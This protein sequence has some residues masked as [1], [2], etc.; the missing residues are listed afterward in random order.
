LRDVIYRMYDKTLIVI[1]VLIIGFVLLNLNTSVV[2]GLKNPFNSKSIKKSFDK[3]VKKASDSVKKNADAAKKKTDDFFKKDSKKSSNDDDEESNSLSVA[4][5]ATATAATATAA[6][7]TAATATAATVEPIQTINDVAQAPLPVDFR[8]VNGYLE[9]I[10][11][12][13]SDA[14]TMST[15]IR[16]SVEEYKRAYDEASNNLTRL[17]DATKSNADSTKTIAEEALRQMDAIQ[18][19]ISTKAVDIQAQVNSNNI[20]K[21]EIG[22]RMNEMRD[23]E[24]NVSDKFIDVK[25]SEMNAAQSAEDARRALA[26]ILPT[27][28]N[29]NVTQSVGAQSVEGFT[30]FKTS[31]LE[32]YTVYSNPNSTSSGATNKNAFDLENDLVDKINNFNTAYYTYLSQQTPTAIQSTA[33]TTARTNL[34]TAISNLNTHISSINSSTP[35][36]SDAVF[37]ASHSYIKTTASQIDTLRSDLDMKMLEILKA[38][39][40]TP[41][42]HTINHDAA[43]YTTILW[44][45]LATSALY[46]IFVKIE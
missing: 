30:G 6:T 32:G 35:K 27:S 23:I 17:S 1:I 10:K 31:V 12:Y 39:Q 45:A 2:E 36:I 3:A 5:A 21:N 22:A 40:G 14:Q 25:K 33:L 16:G 38:K 18:R 8:E 42:D 37:D 20:V 13:S 26:G 34:N 19:D 15:S 28:A 4:T 9:K 43:A 29:N 46:F 44:T 7:A 24:K 11:N 41:M